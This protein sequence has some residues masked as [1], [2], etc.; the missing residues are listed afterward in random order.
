MLMRTAY[1][2]IEARPSVCLYA[3]VVMFLA[4]FTSFAVAEDP[5]IS[6]QRIA[7][8]I[9]IDG[10]LDDPAWR[11]ARVITLTQQSGDIVI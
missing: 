5:S 2:K 7:R 3:L 4:T 11:E 10:K 9:A 6:A 1:I 8:S